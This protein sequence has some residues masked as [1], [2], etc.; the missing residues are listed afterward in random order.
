MMIVICSAPT[1]PTFLYG[2]GGHYTINMR[3]PNNNKMSVP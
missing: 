3:S 1:A 2:V